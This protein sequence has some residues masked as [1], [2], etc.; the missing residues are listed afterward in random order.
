MAIRNWDGHTVDRRFGAAVDNT[1][2][3]RHPIP[4]SLLRS[5][6][7]LRFTRVRV[8]SMVSLGC[9]HRRAAERSGLHQTQ[10]LNLPLGAP[11]RAIN[12]HGFGSDRRPGFGVS[13]RALVSVRERT[14]PSTFPLIVVGRCHPSL[15]PMRPL[16]SE[17]R[18]FSDRAFDLYGRLC[19][20]GPWS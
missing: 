7:F 6:P 14:R 20:Q 9:G 8:T 13:S 19:R 15:R 10:R 4:A 17:R 5:L 12:L 16:A 1:R 11:R 3:C 18:P 2:R